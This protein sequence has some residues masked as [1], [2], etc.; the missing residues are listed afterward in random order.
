MKGLGETD[1]FFES[2]H[3]RI[4]VAGD[5]PAGIVGRLRVNHDKFD[6][7]IPKYRLLATIYIL[8]LEEPFGMKLERYLNK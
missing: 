4:L 6:F 1:D 8:R 3:E 2:L 5:L 7:N